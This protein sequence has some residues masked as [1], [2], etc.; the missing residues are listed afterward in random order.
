[1]HHI[2]HIKISSWPE[3]WPFTSFSKSNKALFTVENCI[4]YNRTRGW[5][6]ERTV[7]VERRSVI[8]FNELPWLKELHPVFTMLLFNHSV[9]SDSLQPHGLQHAKLLIPLLS[10]GA[11]S[12][13]CSLNFC[14]KVCIIAEHDYTQRLNKNHKRYS[15]LCVSL[16]LTASL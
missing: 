2:I 3:G 10:R 5:E 15:K 1:M 16:I 14:Y 9:M 6:R 11:C 12:N 13:S 4:V 7:S 8:Q